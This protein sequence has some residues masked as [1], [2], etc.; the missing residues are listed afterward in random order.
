MGVLDVAQSVIAIPV[1]A[2]L[3]A[4]TD[5]NPS[6]GYVAKKVF[7]F[8]LL[9]MSILGLV[10]NLTGAIDVLNTIGIGNVITEV[11]GFLS[12]P[13]SAVILFCVGYNFTMKKE[14]M[15]D[16]LEI[17]G[18][19]FVIFAVICT[20]I[21]AV[22]FFM[23]SVDIQTRWAVLLYCALPG[24]YL[25]ASLGKTNEDRAVAASICSV[26]T[27]VCLVI[28]CIMTVVVA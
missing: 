10:L 24:S 2:I 7:T 5:K 27:V 4:D 9:L 14:N 17:C 28:F 18:W 20:V 25:T 12:G 13:V 19:H 21:Q 22:F 6:A 1:I 23:P 3:S 15:K 16:V 11:T 26:L 8:P